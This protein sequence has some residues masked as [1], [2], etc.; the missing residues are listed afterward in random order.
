MRAHIHTDA[1]SI[2]IT[3]FAVA[4]VFHAG[5]MIGAELASRGMPSVGKALGG[6]FTFNGG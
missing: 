3:A 5:R 1:L 4:L 2:T 6:Y